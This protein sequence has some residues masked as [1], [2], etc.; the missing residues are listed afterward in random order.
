MLNL[1]Q[2]ELSKYLFKWSDHLS[3]FLEEE[4]IVVPNI[5]QFTQDITKIIQELQTQL[6]NLAICR[7]FNE[8]MV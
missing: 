6:G 1:I 2:A 7:T 4:V 5:D 3:F 8:S